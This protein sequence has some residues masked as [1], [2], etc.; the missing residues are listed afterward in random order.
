MLSPET[1]RVLARVIVGI[2]I[3][4]LGLYIYVAAPLG[5][6]YDYED[7]AVLVIWYTFWIGLPVIGWAVCNL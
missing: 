2:F 4:L 7:P 3:T 1:K 5:I 6:W